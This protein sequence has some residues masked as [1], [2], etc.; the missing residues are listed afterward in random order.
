MPQVKRGRKRK[1]PSDGPKLMG[2]VPEAV[3]VTE[4][5]GGHVEMPLLEVEVPEG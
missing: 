2:K 1:S 5:Q 3:L 4:P